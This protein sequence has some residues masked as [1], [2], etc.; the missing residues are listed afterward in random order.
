VCVCVFKAFEL[1]QGISVVVVVFVV[2]VV[3]VV[4]V[5]GGGCGLVCFGV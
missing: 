4:A 3:V 1:N 5:N 2:V